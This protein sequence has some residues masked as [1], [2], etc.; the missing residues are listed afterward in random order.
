MP[1]QRNPFAGVLRYKL[2]AN[3]IIE[4]KRKAKRKK[5]QRKKDAMKDY[6]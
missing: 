4:N 3:K 2:F 1:K 5:W 6:E